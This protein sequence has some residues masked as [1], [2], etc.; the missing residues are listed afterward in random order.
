MTEEIRG[1]D[2]R[3][4]C[5]KPHRDK[6]HYFICNLRES[7]IKCDWKRSGY[8]NLQNHLECGHID[9]KDHIRKWKRGG[10]G[11]LDGYMITATDKAKNIFAWINWIVEENLSFSFCT[12]RL[13]RENT[14]LKKISRNTLKK[15]MTLIF[16]EVKSVISQK[17]PDTFG[18]IID[19]WSLDS[20]HYSAVFATFLD[21]STDEIVDFLLTCNVAE[22]VDDSTDFDS[23]LPE[24]LK[25]FGFTAADWFDVIVDALQAV[26]KHVDVNTFKDVVEFISADNCSTHKKLAA[27]SGNEI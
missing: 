18:L 1:N 4:C 23:L 24:S 9:Y 6:P 19:G 15:Y 8:H 10:K 22:D 2:I 21:S 25:T 7:D 16:E 5:Y 12:K 26:D 11:P 27:D 13:T 17:L 20:H 3:D 14:K